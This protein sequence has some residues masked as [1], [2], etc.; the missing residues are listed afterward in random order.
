M[1]RYH[2]ADEGGLIDYPAMLGFLARHGFDPRACLGDGARGARPLPFVY[3]FGRSHFV[4]SYFGANVY[5][6]N[7]TVGLEQ[8]EV[9][10]WVTGKFVM[11]V[12]E[13]PERNRFLWVVVE[14][15]A[16]EAANEERK[17]TA[18][19]AILRALMR[20]NSEYANYVPA[21][22]RTP[23]VDLRTTADPEWFPAGVKH[24]YTRP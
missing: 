2:I 17:D 6:E 24:R 1:I 23:S 11:Q 12:R 21:A 5:P 16:G 18:A 19:A 7:V 22:Y 13:D 14:L 4:V 10:E 20:L 9:R 8:S 3:V 15:A